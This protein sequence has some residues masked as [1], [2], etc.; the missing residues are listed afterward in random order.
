MGFQAHVIVDA[1][2]F[3]Q[4]SSLAAVLRG[5]E[6]RFQLFGDT[7]NT[8]ARMESTG[9]KQK[10]QISKET[11][12]RLI[13]CGKSSWAV[14]RENTIVVKG[15]GEMQTYWQHTKQEVPHGTIL[16]SHW[17]HTNHRF[18]SVLPTLSRIRAR[19]NRTSFLP[20]VAFV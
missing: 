13:A 18:T 19:Q 6:S 17:R 16:W 1:I 5:D 8:A 10:I 4:W 11:S 12:N 3:E 15:K 9:L 20:V 7:V 2:W 14:P